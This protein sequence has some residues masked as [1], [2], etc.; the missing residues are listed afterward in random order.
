MDS[1]LLIYL[2]QRVRILSV[3]SDRKFYNQ[4]S[5]NR[6]GKLLAHIML[7]VQASESRHFFQVM[8]LLAVSCIL[9][10]VCLLALFSGG[11]LLWWVKDP[12]QCQ[13]DI[14]SWLFQLS[15]C[16]T[17]ASLKSHAPM[18]IRT[19]GFLNPIDRECKRCYSQKWYEGGTLSLPKF[20][21]CW[22]QVEMET[23]E[24]PG[25]DTLPKTL[26]PFLQRGWE[27]ESPRVLS[28]PLDKVFV[29]FTGNS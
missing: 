24:M 29:M 2:V 14:F 15:P 12:Q 23:P 20:K 1:S 10:P 26:H 27:T 3:T 5:L 17:L 22:S 9:L 28:Q 25:E 11:I 8:R 18:R 6:S 21:F 4:I 7:S 19:Q 16:V 13:A